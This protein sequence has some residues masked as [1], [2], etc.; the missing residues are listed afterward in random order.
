MP[1]KVRAMKQI[2]LDLPKKAKSHKISGFKLTSTHRSVLELINAGLDNKA[3]CQRAGVKD[4]TIYYVKRKYKD[5]IKKPEEANNIIDIKQYDENI[6][7]ALKL[8]ILRI[9]NTISEYN[10]QKASLTQ[11]TTA[12]GTLY[13]KHRL[14]IGRSTANISTQVINSLPD[15]QVKIIKEMTMRLKKSMLI[16]HAGT[17]G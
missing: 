10:L 7:N 5:L 4:H 16:E 13:D 15:E 6:D 3:I 17:K 14:H 1:K 2:E 9:A 11:L 12:L 8:N